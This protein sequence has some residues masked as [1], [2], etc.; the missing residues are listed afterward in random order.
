MPKVGSKSWFQGIG[1]YWLIPVFVLLLLFCLCFGALDMCLRP[2]WK[3][4]PASDISGYGTFEEG[5][6]LQEEEKLF[7]QSRHHSSSQTSM[8][9]SEHNQVRKQCR[10]VESPPSLFHIHFLVSLGALVLGVSSNLL[11]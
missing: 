5:R 1:H 6:P 9:K 8:T 10:V 4:S 7:D 2:V 3:P 11:Q